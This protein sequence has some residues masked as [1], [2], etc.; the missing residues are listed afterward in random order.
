MWTAL[1]ASL[2]ALALLALPAAAF[3]SGGDQAV[4]YQLDPAHDGFQS[5]GPIAAPLSQ[6]WSVTLPGAVSYPLIVNGVVYV[7]ASVSSGYGTTLYAIEQ[8]TGATLWSHALGG[9]YNFS[10]LAYDSGQVFTVNFGGQL[11]AFNAASG[12]TD[13]SMSLP[14]QSSFTSPPTAANG[15]VY[16][17]GAGSGGTLYA[18]SETSG[19]VAWTAS[20]EN[21][22]HSS[23]AVS[24]TGVYVGYACDQDYDFNPLTGAQLWHFAG[25]CEGGGGKTPVL[26]GGYVFNRDSSSGNVALSATAGAQQG[27]FGASH[28]PAAGGGELYAA[29]GSTLSAVSDWGLGTTDWSFSGDGHLDTAPLIDGALIFEGS[30]SGNVYALNA[31]DGSTAWSA[32]A[33]AAIAA[34]DEQN[35][36]SLTGLG[37]AE[38]TLIVPAGNSLVAYTG[39]NIGSG[40]PSDTLAPSVPTTPVAGSLAGADVGIWTALPTGYTYLWSLCDSSGANCAAIPTN[41]TGESYTPPSS[42]IGDTLEVT[43]TATNASGSSN[44]A[45]SAPSS[46]IAPPPPA[47]QSIPTISGTAGVGQTLSAS[48]GVWSGSPTGYAYQWLR[49]QT[50]CTAIAGATSSTHVVTSADAAGALEVQVVATNAT[51]AGKA[52]SVPTATVPTP[53]AMTLTSSSNPLLAGATVTFEAIVSPNVNGGTLTFSLNGTAIAGCSGALGNGVIGA[54][55][56][57]PIDAAGQFTVTASYSGDS[58]YLASS[59]SLTQTV[60][61]AASQGT[62]APA[63]A[64]PTPVGVVINGNPPQ[65][66][67]S[68]TITYTETGDVTSTVCTLDGIGTPCGLTSATLAKLSS[69]HHTFEVTVSGPGASAD[70]QVSWVMAAQPAAT[71]AAKKPTPAHKPV[72]KKKKIKKKKKKPAKHKAAKR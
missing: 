25:A 40:I 48:T 54:R 60:T 12:A 46:P 32:A 14:G 2:G 70:A 33:G 51:G 8:A 29:S 72:K 50:T 39:A 6:A 28:A 27:S 23:P 56:I 21:G 42:D 7:T 22:D 38:N 47:V 49:C 20:V 36:V 67:S 31:A 9:T 43:V 52:N 4:A 41:A 35:A 68:P 69:G 26:A 65:T 59:A 10:G 61:A 71:S 64:L 11:T 66:D 34:P 24:S 18:V 1:A 13:W 53:T 63:P 30:S 5:T 62:S 57:V 37:V 3:A 15:Y 44:S 45:T 16:V 19:S 17:G 58:A 55:C